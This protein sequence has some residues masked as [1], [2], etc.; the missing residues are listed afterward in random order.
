MDPLSTGASPN[1]APPAMLAL[2]VDAFVTARTAERDV[3]AAEVVRLAP[4]VAEIQGRLAG[5]RRR[6]AQTQEQIVQVRKERAG[7]EERFRRATD[8]RLEGL[9]EARKG[10]RRTM[11]EVAKLAL[12]DVAHFPPD[13]GRT[14]R[15][16][17]AQTRTA[18]E[19]RHHDAALHHAALEAHDPE[20]LKKGI[21]L[22]VAAIVLFL[23][24]FFSPVIVRSFSSDAGTIAPP[25]VSG[26]A[27]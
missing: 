17:I 27:P 7:D 15:T 23:L 24:L 4:I 18:A 12:T 25:P 8:A 19:T 14:E 10:Y 20:A 5:V 21:T 1:L 11:G 9:G 3:A 22:S 16:T 2:G 26:A 6:V 13:V